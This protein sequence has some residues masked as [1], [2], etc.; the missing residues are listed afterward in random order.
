MSLLVQHLLL[1]PVLLVAAAVTIWLRAWR[2]TC[3][4]AGVALGAELAVTW[5]AGSVVL[6]TWT[7]G[8]FFLIAAANVIVVAAGPPNRSNRRDKL[9]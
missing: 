3:L 2:I 4:V 5:W 8:A 6:A 1:L 9:T 7:M